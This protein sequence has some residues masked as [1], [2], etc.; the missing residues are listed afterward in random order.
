MR[1]HR[2]G[3]ATLGLVALI[4]LLASGL[5]RLVAR[6]AWPWVLGLSLVVW[7]FFAQFFRHPVR[8]TPQVE[9]AIISPADG[10]IVA[11]ERVRED[12]FYREERLKISIYMSALNVHVNRVP[13]AGQVVYSRYHPGRY[14]VA[15]HPKASTL[16]ERNSIVI[17]TESGHG[18]LVRQ[19]AG[20]IAR[21]IVSYL[22]TGQHVEAGQ[23][24]G[25]IKFGSRCDIFLPT[26]SQVSVA[27]Q[28]KVRGGETIL[29]HLP[30]P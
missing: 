18:V 24:L 1:I 23:E 10:T 28:D 16:N 7:G 26:E 6:R 11:I 14:L 19:I 27:L 2:E 8:R 12:E 29:A 15:F 5:S 13:C 25:F 9:G 20:L 3:R 22:T 30:R 21:R 4:G 17:Q